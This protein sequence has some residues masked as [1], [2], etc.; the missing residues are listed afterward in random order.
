MVKEAA[1]GDEVEVVLDVTPFYAEGGGQV[2]DQGLLVGPEGQLEIK[3]TTRPAP[4]L[5]LHKGIVTKG[6]IREGRATADVGQ[7]DDSPGCGT[8]S[9]GDAP[10]A[11]GFA[12]SCW[13]LM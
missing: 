11:C 9:H 7:C 8:K 1:E 13:V 12:G 10:G 4:T 6:R 3:E 5:I 2:G